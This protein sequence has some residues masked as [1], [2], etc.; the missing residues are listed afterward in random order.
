MLKFLSNEVA[1]TEGTAPELLDG[2]D[3]AEV[4]VLL[5][6]PQAARISPAAATTDAAAHLLLPRVLAAF[7]GFTMPGTIGPVP[8]TEL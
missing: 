1:E 3:V 7:S 2:A 8:L 6:L 4:D 5:E